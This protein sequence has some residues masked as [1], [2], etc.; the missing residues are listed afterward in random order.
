MYS[1]TE[2]PARSP[3]DVDPADQHP[4]IPP[5]WDRWLSDRRYALHKLRT[6][7]LL[8]YQ[9]NIE[10][11]GYP[12]FGRTVSIVGNRD[13]H[14]LD[15]LHRSLAWNRETERTRLLLACQHRIPI[16]SAI[17]SSATLETN[18]PDHGVGFAIRSTYMIHAERRG[19]SSKRSWLVCTTFSCVPTFTRNPSPRMPLGILPCPE[20]LD[21]S[22]SSQGGETVGQILKSHVRVVELDEDLATRDPRMFLDDCKYR[23]YPGARNG[24]SSTYS[25]QST[26]FFK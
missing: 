16:H 23:F 11:P 18:D 14:D 1:Y 19:R 2:H 3:C 26:T 10:S 25:R 5:R 24:G 17:G 22:T 15:Q 4:N 6:T 8:V 9:T 13:F 21:P 12:S 7:F 20:I